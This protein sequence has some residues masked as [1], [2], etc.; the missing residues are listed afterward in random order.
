MFL[1][2]QTYCCPYTI[3]IEGNKTALFYQ[4]DDAKDKNYIQCF[5]DYEISPNV[6]YGCV[7]VS[8]FLYFAAPS[9]CL[10]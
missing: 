2:T 9:S 3:T 1:S 7:Y 5:Y 6:H 10:Y 4:I 8:I